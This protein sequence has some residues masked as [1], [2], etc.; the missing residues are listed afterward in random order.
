MC[1]H[2]RRGACHKGCACTFAH[3]DEELQASIYNASSIV[4]LF[5]LGD[6]EAY[7]PWWRRRHDL[8]LAFAMHG[9]LIEVTRCS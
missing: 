8:Q 2:W 5:E 7:E 3:G 1:T 4:D 6:R 9:T